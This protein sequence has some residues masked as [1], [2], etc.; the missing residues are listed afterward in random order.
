M[1]SF[2][3]NYNYGRNKII[4]PIKRQPLKIKSESSSSFV[5]GPPVVHHCTLHKRKYVHCISYSNTDCKAYIFATDIALGKTQTPK[6]ILY[7]NNILHMH[8]TELQ[9]IHAFTTD[10]KLGKIQT[11]KDMLL[12]T[13]YVRH[14]RE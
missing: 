2:T 4:I 14:K 1:I 10:I 11:A 7:I 8:K 5:L 3:A 9:N 12:I 6:H 13:H